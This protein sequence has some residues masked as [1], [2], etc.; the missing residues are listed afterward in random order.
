V[1]PTA[2]E[3]DSVALVQARAL[4][5]ALADKDWLGWAWLWQV[6][7]GILLAAVLIG[8]YPILA[9]INKT[10]GSLRKSGAKVVELR[11]EVTIGCDPRC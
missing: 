7:A 4:H 8:L 9:F 1:T 10:A 2:V 5:V 3:N 11:H 6:N